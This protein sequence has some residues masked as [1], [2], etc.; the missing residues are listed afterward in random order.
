MQF[1][2]SAGFFS[3]GVVLSIIGSV[4]G[5]LAIT[6]L[7][8]YSSS[9]YGPSSGAITFT[10]VGWAAALVGNILVCVGITR[11]LTKIDALPIHMAVGP[12]AVTVPALPVSPPASAPSDV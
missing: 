4:I 9:Y 7:I 8:S 11:A 3:G 1:E 12:Q 5:L 2:P 10:F 6:T